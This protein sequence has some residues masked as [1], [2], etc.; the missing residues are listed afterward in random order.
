MLNVNNT[1]NMMGGMGSTTIAS[2]ARTP[3]G[4]PIPVRIRSR[5]GGIPD[6]VDAVAMA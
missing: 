5:S 1:S 6:G 3:T 2:T 4:T